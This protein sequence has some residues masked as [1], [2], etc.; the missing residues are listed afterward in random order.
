MC[1]LASIERDVNIFKKMGNE[2]Q[3]GT[4][5]HFPMNTSTDKNK[6]RGSNPLWS[7]QVPKNKSK[8]SWQVARDISMNIL[9]KES[10]TL[11][12]SRGTNA[13]LFF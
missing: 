10:P 2:Q 7:K 5:H 11:S 6:E 8:P 12:L 9:S 4:S 13:D 1:H 3:S